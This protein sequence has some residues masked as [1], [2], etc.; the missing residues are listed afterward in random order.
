MEDTNRKN[1][2]KWLK[3]CHKLQKEEKGDCEQTFEENEL[4]QNTETETRTTTMAAAAAATCS[5]KYSEI[6]FWDE[7]VFI[8]ISV[9]GNF[10]DADADADAVADADADPTEKDEN[11][12]KN[13]WG[14]SHSTVD[15]ILA[16]H[17]VVQG[18][19]PSAPKIPL[20]EILKLLRLIDSTA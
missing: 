12:I 15:S 19:N 17:S 20:D 10:A 7:C 14:G 6:G 4:K 13:H 8:F 11:K 16:S 18:L 1:A 9:P 5:G 2:D 3:G